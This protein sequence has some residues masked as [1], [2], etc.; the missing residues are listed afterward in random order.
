[1]R[2]RRHQAL[3]CG[4]STSPLEDVAV[5]I[6][7]RV[8]LVILFW[9]LLAF[10]A[11]V[12]VLPWVPHTATQWIALLIFGPVLVVGGEYLGD[13]VLGSRLLARQ[14]SWVRILLV[15][16]LIVGA[17]VLVVSLVALFSSSNNRWSGP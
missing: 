17:V 16:L 12:N 9:A 11:L 1:V 2:P 8:G 5:P 13:R 3:L 14:P 7:R 15:V 6:I 10:C 4:P